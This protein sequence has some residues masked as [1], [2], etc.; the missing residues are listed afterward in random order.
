MIKQ[1]KLINSITYL[2]VVL[3]LTGC[4]VLTNNSPAPVE[5]VENN[6]INK[7]EVYTVQPG[8]SLYTIA[9]QY[10]LDIQQ[11]LQ[12][13]HIRDPYKIYPKQ[14]LQLPNGK[15]WPRVVDLNKEHIPRVKYSEPS[16]RQ[17]KKLATPPP[18][19]EQV[20]QLSKSP[21]RWP[22]NNPNIVS[23]YVANSKLHKGIDFSGKSGE[24]VIAAKDGKVVYSGS[25]LRGYGNLLIIKHDDVFLSAYAHNSKLLVSEGD[26]VAAGQ[27]IAL[28]GDTDSNQVK[29]HFEIRKHGQPIDPMLLLN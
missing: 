3:S 18:R 8:D 19:Q 20:A 4:G 12:H 26:K 11:I 16:I 17:V 15:N 13:N 1:F 2:I 14:K 6:P 22:V 10:G 29:L 9:W 21:W 24:P 28:M 5:L 7:L 25:G 23:K 27:K